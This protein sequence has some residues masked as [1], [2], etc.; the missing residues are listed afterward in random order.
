MAK[1]VKNEVGEKG[2]GVEEVVTG[3]QESPQGEQATPQAEA[4]TNVV[5][6]PQVVSNPFNPDTHFAVDKVKFSEMVI[7]LV[8]NKPQRYTSES[9]VIHFAEMLGVTEYEAQKEKYNEIENIFYA[10]QS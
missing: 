9:G 8:R 2:M 4:K 5:E 7:A 1:K 10:S 6:S 3:N